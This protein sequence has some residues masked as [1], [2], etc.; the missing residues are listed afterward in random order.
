[1]IRE[2]Q[3]QQE[4]EVTDYAVGCGCDPCLAV[5][6][7]LRRRATLQERFDPAGPSA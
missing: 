3:P 7:W 4:D 5:K 1:M 6:E 2:A